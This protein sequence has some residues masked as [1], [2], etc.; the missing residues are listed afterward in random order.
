MQKVRFVFI[1]LY[2]FLVA[3]GGA[4]RE[5]YDTYTVSVNS[6]IVWSPPTTYTDGNPLPDSS[7][8]GYNIYVGSSVSTLQLFTSLT[9]SDA[10]QFK[11]SSIGKGHFYISV[12][13]LDT[14]GIE[15]NFST[16]LILNII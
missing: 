2:L 9:A 1:I 4:R 14:S 12:T 6:S 7:I 11:L 15:S 13:C 16:T 5:G 10:R 8:S 3:C